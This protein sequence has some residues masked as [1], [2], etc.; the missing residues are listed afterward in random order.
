V[1]YRLGICA[2]RFGDLAVAERFLTWSLEVEVAKGFSRHADEDWLVVCE[3]VERDWVEEKR[4]WVELKKKRGKNTNNNKKGGDDEAE[5]TEEEKLALSSR[6]YM[7][8]DRLWTYAKLKKGDLQDD[9]QEG[10]GG[11]EGSAFL[12]ERGWEARMLA[13]FAGRDCWRGGE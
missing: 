5:A 7:L 1:L 10:G 2:K 13:L 8:H 11:F 12:T 9:H 3:W 6:I 4:V